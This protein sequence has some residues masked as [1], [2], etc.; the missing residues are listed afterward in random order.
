MEIHYCF[1]GLLYN[2]TGILSLSP[3]LS[4]SLF[5]F[6]IYTVPVSC[7]C[8][9]IAQVWNREKITL[10]FSRMLETRRNIELIIRLES[11][12]WRNSVR[13]WTS[14][15][16]FLFRSL[17]LSLSFSLSLSV[18]RWHLCRCD[19]EVLRNQNSRRNSL[20]VLVRLISSCALARVNCITKKKLFSFLSLTF[21][22]FHSVVK[23]WIDLIFG[24]RVRISSGHVWKYLGHS[25]TSLQIVVYLLRF[26]WFERDSPLSRG[27]L[28]VI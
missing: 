25:L 6:I 4:L 13:L 18:C 19:L 11:S 1:P 9:P 26:R 21:N 22:F 5:T 3:S 17:S 20:W 28:G 10:S 8:F 16:L 2:P 14:N 23:C 24:T 7:S 27:N 15:N 12:N